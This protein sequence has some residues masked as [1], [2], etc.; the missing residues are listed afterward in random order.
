MMAKINRCKWRQYNFYRIWLAMRSKRFC[1]YLALI[2]NI[3]PAIELRIAVENFAPGAVEWHPDAIAVP[4]T[5]V[6]L[7][8]TRTGGLLAA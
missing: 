3:R 8:T 2:S 7:E 1:H 5:G 6:M 4:G